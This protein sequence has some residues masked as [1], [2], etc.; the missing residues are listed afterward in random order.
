MSRIL[1]PGPAASPAP[2]VVGVVVLKM[3]DNGHMVIETQLPHLAMG[4]EML[5]KA[6]GQLLDAAKAQAEKQVQA[7]PANLLGPGGRVNL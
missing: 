3:Q 4:V 2:T 1:V 6:A 7:A 5:V